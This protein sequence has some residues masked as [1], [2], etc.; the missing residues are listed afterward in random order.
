MRK[1]KILIS[2]AVSFCLMPKIVNAVCSNSE[3]VRLNALANNITVNYDVEKGTKTVTGD[4]GDGPETYEKYTYQFLGNVYGLTEELKLI[5]KNSLNDQIANFGF[6]NANNGLIRFDDLDPDK[7]ITYTIEVYGT[8]ECGDL[9]RSINLIVPK[10][11]HNKLN[12]ICDQAREYYLCQDYIAVDIDY[13]DFEFLAK[14][15]EYIDKRDN[16]QNQEEEGK[17][18]KGNFLDFLIKYKYFFIGGGVLIG[19]GVVTF[20]MIKRK[21]RIV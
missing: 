11:N 2:L 21:R 14:V 12:M 20:V 1:F 5:V 7:I 17:E 6:G 13:D 10:I 9:I 16:K 3:I 19:A 15:N 8:G 18:N 4:F